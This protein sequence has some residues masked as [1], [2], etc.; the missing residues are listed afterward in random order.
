MR[1]NVNDWRRKSGYFGG[2]S[3]VSLGAGVVVAIQSGTLA[4]GRRMR[5]SDTSFETAA[6]GS[7][8]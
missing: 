1:S 6:I 4:D 8:L 7:L 5:C 3:Y 2:V